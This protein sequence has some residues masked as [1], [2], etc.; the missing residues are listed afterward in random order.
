[1]VIHRATGLFLA[2]FVVGSLALPWGNFGDHHAFANDITG[3]MMAPDGA[4]SVTNEM[5]EDP[6][7]VSFSFL[8]SM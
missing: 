1:M 3:T 5:Y 8:S 7:L 6:F 4:L 2:V